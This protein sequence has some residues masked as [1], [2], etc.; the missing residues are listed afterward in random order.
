[1]M[2][3]YR[4]S[5]V[6]EMK[7]WFLRHYENP[8]HNT[9]Y[10]S[11]EGGYIYIWGG[12]YDALEVLLDQF[13]SDQE[14]NLIELAAAELEAESSEWAKIPTIDDMDFG[15]EPVSIYLARTSESFKNIRAEL[16]STHKP[17]PA[18]LNALLFAHVISVLEAFLYDA[19][20]SKL[21]ND[22]YFR[23]FVES[24]PKFKEEK[25]SVADIFKTLDSLKPKAS[26]RIQS[27]VFHRLEIVQQMYKATL[28]I[29]L[30]SGIS[31]LLKAIQKRHDIVHRNCKDKDGTPFEVTAKEV[32]DLVSL[33]ER[34]IRELSDRLDS[35]PV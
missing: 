22:A 4:E 12:P 6:K 20:A 34:F 8:A 5:A 7:E 26:Q 18:F 16:T 11:A 29:E 13:G 23:R 1:M 28:G 15:D 14:E 30:P 3:L 35:L 2:D 21:K 32:E 31:E 33:T 19:F 10:E 27:I 24:D 17:R 9:P 25:L